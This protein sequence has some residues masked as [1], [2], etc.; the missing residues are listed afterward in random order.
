M[1]VTLTAEA[2]SP[3]PAEQVRAALLDFSDRR[4]DLWPQLDP[5]TYAVHWIGP[6]SAMVTEGSPRPRVWSH[7][8][9]DWSHPTRVTWTSTESNFC[10]PGSF[11]SMDITPRDG[12][13]CRVEATWDRTAAGPKGWLMLG[14]LALGGN[15]FLRLATEKSLA[16]LADR[17]EPIAEWDD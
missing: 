3:L 17:L 5:E 2:E 14:L 13:G 7:D 4:L 12:G 1:R 10:T 15:R 16:D 9:Y 11:V 8:R 6:T